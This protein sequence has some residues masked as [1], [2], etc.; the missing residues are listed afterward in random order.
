M[1][2]TF[3]GSPAVAARVRAAIRKQPGRFDNS[4]WFGN[5]WTDDI[6]SLVTP[7]PVGHLQRVLASPVPITSDA[8]DDLTWGMVACVGSF[9]AIFAASPYSYISLGRQMISLSEGGTYPIRDYASQELGLPDQDASHYLFL[10]QR[11]PEEI[12]AAL[13][14]IA[15]RT[16]GRWGWEPLWSLTHARLGRP[17]ADQPVI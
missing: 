7:V 6:D 17:V 14:V 1:R 12:D 4:Q 16:P 2:R 5:V 8:D 10:P 13:S 9:A 15:D 3:S 11:S